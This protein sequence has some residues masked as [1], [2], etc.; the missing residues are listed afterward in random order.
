MVDDEAHFITEC[1]LTQD[2]RDIFYKAAS[3]KN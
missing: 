1:R 3:E 2:Y